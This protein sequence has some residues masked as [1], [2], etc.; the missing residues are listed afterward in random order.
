MGVAGSGVGVSEEVNVGVWVGTRISVL[1]G[2]AA[3][4]EVGVVTK[5]SNGRSRSQ[6]TKLSETI[7][8]RI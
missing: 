4:V 1:L 6:E 5:S 8:N 3:E 2:V 7:S